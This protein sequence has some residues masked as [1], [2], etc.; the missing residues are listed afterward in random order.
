MFKAVTFYLQKL[1]SSKFVIKGKCKKCGQC[2]RNIVFFIQDSTIKTESQFE[3]LKRFNKSYNH[4]FISGVDDDKSLLFT[5]KSINPDNTCKDYFFR[6]INCRNYP[7]VNKKFI[8]NGGKPL[9]GCGFY[10][11]VDKKFSNY[12]KS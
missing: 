2:C 1:F 10:F 7:K 11:D 3:D 9:D 6:S 12:L 4:F 8:I 5:C